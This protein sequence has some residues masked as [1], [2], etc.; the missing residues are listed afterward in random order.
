LLLSR[1][2]SLVPPDLVSIPD[3]NQDYQDDNDDDDDDDDEDNDDANDSRDELDEG[4]G[5][6]SKKK[7]NSKKSVVAGKEDDSRSEVTA[8]EED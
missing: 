8:I 2:Y 1:T 3:G 5:I 7:G 6:S 4:D